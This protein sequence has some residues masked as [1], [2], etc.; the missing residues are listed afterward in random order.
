MQARNLVARFLVEQMENDPSF[1]IYSAQNHR[2]DFKPY[3]HQQLLLW[4]L[5]PAEKIRTIVGDEIGLGK[6]VE[7]ILTIKH[8]QKRGCKRFLLLVPKSLKKQWKGELQK[9]FDPIDIFELYSKNIPTLCHSNAREGVY[10]ASIDTAKQD[11]NKPYIRSVDW[12][13]VIVDEAHNLGSDSQRDSL[14]SELDVKHK[15]FLSATPHRGDSRRYLRL[16]SHLDGRIKPK[17]SKFDSPNFYKKT[18]NAL[19]HRRT[20]RLVNEIEGERIFPHC[21]VRAV[22]TEAT[23]IEK[24]FSNEITDFLQSVLRR[25]DDDSPVGLLVALMRKRAS[26]SPRAAINTLERIIQPTQEGVAVK[27]TVAEKV[28]GESFE[29]VGEAL[30]N[31]DAE[32]VDDVY[33]AVFEKYREHLTPGEIARLSEFIKLAKEIENGRDSKLEVLKDILS[34][35]VGRGEKVIVF[36]EYK[37]TL[38]YLWEK[39][40]GSFRV[41]TAY[42]GLSENEYERRFMEFLEN[43]DV[44]IATDV[45]SEGLNLQKANIVVNY[46]PPWTPIKLEQ[47]MGRVWRMGQ[48]RDVTVYNLFLGTRSDEELAELLY[49][50]MLRI[51]DALSDVKNIVGESIEW[52]TSRVIESVEEMIDTSSLPSSVEYKNKVRRVTEH[53][54]IKA[55]LQ[56]ELDDFVNAIMAHI[57][58]LRFELSSK[59]IYPKD[60]AISVKSVANKLGLLPKKENEELV[61][62]AISYILGEE[63]TGNP[64]IPQLLDRLKEFGDDAPEYLVVLSERDGVDYVGI[65]EVEFDSHVMRVP[66]IV[67]DEELLFGG[68]A[69]SYLLNVA[70]SAVVPDDVYTRE[71]LQPSEFKVKGGLM[72]VLNTL[73]APLREYGFNV[74]VKHI[75]VDFICRILRLSSESLSS[76]SKYSANV[77]FTA[78]KFAEEYE[79]SR[80]RVF[81]ERKTLREYDYYSYRKEE[82]NLPEGRR[83][84]ERYVEVKGHGKGGEFFGLPEEEYEFGKKAGKKYW[85]YLVW[86]V[87][88]GNPVLVAFQDPLNRNLFNVQIK[89]EEIRILRKVFVLTFKSQ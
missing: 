71:T 44:L 50:K 14:I 35:H 87:Y 51:R 12:D 1:I 52:A 24:T 30:E 67:T 61:K 4:R 16:L 27:Q 13:A 38:D 81:E 34:L 77:G 22:V 18:H 56:G 42:G 59:R 75:E 5:A 6:T 85:L 39:L 57:D 60:S 46:E 73:L 17:D 70:Q 48:E 69:L 62:M 84:S 86:N 11:N 23:E 54:L 64:K 89:E 66:L 19:I 3:I 9:F 40:S 49:T 47:R 8:L 88:E 2:G 83:E 53:Q 41:V 26:S 25:A 28:L 31:V 36:T 21:E 72:N 74:S 80:G 32:E 33:N 76:S 37:D 78:E 65:A 79:K 63:W 29:D 45:A 58:R 20:K 55:Q 82:E 15:I 43:A 10:L 7:A 68:N